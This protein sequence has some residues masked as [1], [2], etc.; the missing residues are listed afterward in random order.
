MF[1]WL[2]VKVQWRVDSDRYQNRAKFEPKTEVRLLH[3]IQSEVGKQGTKRGE[4]E[5]RSKRRMIRKWVKDAGRML[6]IT[7]FQSLSSATLRP[8][9]YK[10]WFGRCLHGYTLSCAL[11]L[12]FA[13]FSLT[14]LVSSYYV[15][16]IITKSF[17]RFRIQLF[18]FHDCK[19]H[20]NKPYHV[21]NRN[22]SNIDDVHV[23]VNSDWS[24][25][26]IKK[27]KQHCFSFVDDL[28]WQN[29][30]IVEE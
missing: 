9:G 3:C 22:F 8:L 28:T 10:I 19:V 25:W 13:S 5:R 4:Q 16:S 27:N 21:G 1:H 26:K 20:K 2:D 29:T 23:D 15:L 14:M 30:R 17:N 7:L 24:S 18:S 12:S 6:I 11:E